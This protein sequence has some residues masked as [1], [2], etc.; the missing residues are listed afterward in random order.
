MTQIGNVME[1]NNIRT[2]RILSGKCLLAVLVLT[3]LSIVNTAK[4][5]TIL[6]PG[7]FTGG[8]DAYQEQIEQSMPMDNGSKQSTGR[9]GPKKNSSSQ[10]T[11]FSTLSTISAPSALTIPE[12]ADEIKALA[13]GLQYSPEQIYQYVHNKIEFSPVDSTD[14]RNT[15][16]E[17]F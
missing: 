13:R 2:Q 8:V 3:A 4:A 14:R 1:N 9:G 15:G 5:N 6:G 10:L 16:S 11:E 12:T 7:W 17:S